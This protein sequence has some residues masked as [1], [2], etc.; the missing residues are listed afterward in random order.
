[1][2]SRPRH[3][4]RRHIPPLLK[5]VLIFSVRFTVARPQS[6]KGGS[7]S[8]RNTS[9]CTASVVMIFAVTPLF[10]VTVLETAAVLF[11]AVS[12]I[13]CILKLLRH[14]LSCPVSNGQISDALPILMVTFPSPTSKYR[15]PRHSPPTSAFSGVSFSAPAAAW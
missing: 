13:C 6:H 7:L 14:C 11:P 1:M 2:S 8:C 12:V 9:M 3:T 5:A 4:E 15:M 10:T